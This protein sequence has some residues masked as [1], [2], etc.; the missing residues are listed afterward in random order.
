MKHQYNHFIV[1]PDLIGNLYK[2]LLIIFILLP[3]SISFPAYAANPATSSAT[4]TNLEDKIKNLVKENLNTTESNLKE[5]INLKSLTGH[6]GSIKTI[7][8]GNITIETDGNLFQVATADKT[9]ITKGGMPA[10]LLS[11]AIA[12]KVIVIGNPLKEDII[13]AKSIKVIL[14]DTDVVETDAIVA[15]ISSIDTK[16]KVIILTVNKIQ[17][18]YT[19]SKKNF[20]KIAELK[21]GQTIFAITKKYQGKDSLSRA[22]IL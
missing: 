20:I 1:I 13:Q 15:T 2:S 12:D 17:V 4:P 11:L 7:S 3:L 9:I 10:K 19:L 21:P 5:A 22:K 14:E 16:L 6:V 18:P 8:S